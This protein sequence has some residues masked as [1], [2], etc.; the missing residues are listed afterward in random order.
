MS[1]KPWNQGEDEARERGNPHQW[2]T[3]E[4]RLW[5]DGYLAGMAKAASH[6]LRRQ[7]K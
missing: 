4:W 7:G 1:R 5:E 6:F 2:N 3:P